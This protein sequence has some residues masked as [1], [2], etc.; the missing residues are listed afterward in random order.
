MQFYW[1]EQIRIFSVD[2]R[3]NENGRS[4]HTASS[5]WNKLEEVILIYVPNVQTTEKSMVFRFCDADE[6]EGTSFAVCLHYLDKRNNE[7][8]FV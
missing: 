5:K 4:K 6:D 3:W 7:N 1:F 2:L 8:V